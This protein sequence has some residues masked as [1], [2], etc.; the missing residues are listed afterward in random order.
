MVNMNKELFIKEV[1]KL[2]VDINDN[3]LKQLEKY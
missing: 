1:K 2:N 3:Q